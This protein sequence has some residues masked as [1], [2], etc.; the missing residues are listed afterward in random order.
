MAGKIEDAVEE[1]KNLWSQFALVRNQSQTEKLKVSNCVT[2]FQVL[3]GRHSWKV[4]PRGLLETCT[5]ETE[6]QVG[7]CIPKCIISQQNILE[8]A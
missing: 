7:I 3:T 5:R 6:T 4:V 8:I 1:H 2:V